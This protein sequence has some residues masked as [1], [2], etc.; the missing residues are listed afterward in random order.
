MPTIMLIFTV[1]IIIGKFAAITTSVLND[2][3]ATNVTVEVCAISDN[4]MN[5]VELEQRCFLSCDKV[6]VITK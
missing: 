1:F 2:E 5:M 4:N 3:L 6:Y